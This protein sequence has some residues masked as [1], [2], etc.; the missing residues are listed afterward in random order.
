LLSELCVLLAA[1]LLMFAALH[2]IGFRTVPNWLPAA[3]GVLGLTARLADHSLLPALA[4][5]V[6]TFAVLLMFWLTGSIGGGDV[7]LWSAT[8][9]LIP[10]YLVPEFLFFARVILL[11]GVLALVYLLLGRLVRRPAA[12]RRGG[13]L[14]RALRAELWRIRRRAPLPYACAIAAGAIA[15][16]LPLSLQ[17]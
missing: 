13:L 9:L 2:D 7:K 12:S 8:A 3:L 16:I 6:C 5:A 11:G 10:P 17:R 14:R 15:T 1:A 4:V